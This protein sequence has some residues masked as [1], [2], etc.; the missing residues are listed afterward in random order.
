MAMTS[1]ER[2]NV[3]TLHPCDHHEKRGAKFSNVHSTDLPA[4]AWYYCQE[5]AE[6]YLTEHGR[7]YYAAH[8]TIPTEE[9][10]QAFEDASNWHEA[11]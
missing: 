6:Y 4:A 1:N 11:S 5:C 10:A 9:T 3:I 8:A 2:F 7:E